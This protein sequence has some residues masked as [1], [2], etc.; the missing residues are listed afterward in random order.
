M[1]RF[2]AS[3][4]ERVNETRA[5]NGGGSIALAAMNVAQYLQYSITPGWGYL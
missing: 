3:Q 2:S 1:Q 4:A 5:D